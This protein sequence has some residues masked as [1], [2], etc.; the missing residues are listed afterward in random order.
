MLTTPQGDIKTPGK[1][2]TTEAW[3]Q[4]CVKLDEEELSIQVYST[5]ADMAE[6]D[7]ILNG[8]NIVTGTVKPGI[9]PWGEPLVKKLP[10]LKAL[11]F[12]LK[13]GD[14]Y[15]IYYLLILTCEGANVRVSWQIALP[16]TQ[17]Y[18]GKQTSTQRITLR[19]VSAN[20]VSQRRA[21]LVHRRT[22][23]SRPTRCTSLWMRR[24]TLLPGPRLHR[25]VARYGG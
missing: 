2:F 4:Y 18:D 12:D 21:M 24:T 22:S 17:P 5:E 6:H 3:Q 19:C 7:P 9:E 13:E 20:I 10:N 25:T 1:T 14:V 15:E 16:G 23:S 11:G 8:A